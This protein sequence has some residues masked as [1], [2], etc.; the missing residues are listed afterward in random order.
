MIATLS[1][2]FML[3]LPLGSAIL[4]HPERPIRGCGDHERGLI[5]GNSESSVKYMAISLSGAWTARA[6][7]S[8]FSVRGQNNGQNW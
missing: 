4:R 5:S 2:S 6:A 7:G 1:F 8:F 3:D